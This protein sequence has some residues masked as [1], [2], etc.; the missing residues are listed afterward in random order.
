[1]T[2][3]ISTGAVDSKAEVQLCGFRSDGT[4]YLRDQQALFALASQRLY[5]RW[6]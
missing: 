5:Q 3:V 6:F 1:M 2:G 4:L